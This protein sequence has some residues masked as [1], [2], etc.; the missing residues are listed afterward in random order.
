VLTPSILSEIDRK[1]GTVL[2]TI[3]IQNIGLIGR[4]F[5]WSPKD[6]LQ[7][8]SLNIDTSLLGPVRFKIP[9][10]INEKQIFAYTSYSKYLVE[11]ILNAS[12]HLTSVEFE[13][14]PIK[15]H[16]QIVGDYGSF[17]VESAIRYTWKNGI[18]VI[19]VDDPGGFHGAHFKKEGRSAI[20]LNQRTVSRD[21]W[22]FSLFHEFWHVIE[23]KN[24][25]ETFIEYMNIDDLFK[26]GIERDDEEEKASRFATA[27]LIGQP[28]GALLKEAMKLADHDLL[29]LKKATTEISKREGISAGALANY[30]AFRLQDEKHENWWGTA[31][32]LQEKITDIQIITRDILLDN[33]D[34]SNISGM[35]L[36]LLRRALIKT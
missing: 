27:V 17:T 11:I 34:L 15:I 13:R 21:I 3:G 29:K 20:L 7:S 36:D 12:T 26:R 1:N 32:A 25:E 4:I 19:S 18:P 16:R 14:D 31:Q 2:S 5:G 35:D 23:N 9:K 6:I 24:I 30:I 33:I 10:R 8:R 28:P 22:L